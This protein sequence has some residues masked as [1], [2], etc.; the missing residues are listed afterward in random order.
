MKKLTLVMRDHRRINRTNYKLKD[1]K[2]RIC[3]F[4]TKAA[5]NKSSTD[6]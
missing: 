6:R 3:K 4:T 2:C 5:N 1:N